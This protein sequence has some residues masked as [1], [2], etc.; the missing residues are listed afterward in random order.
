MSKYGVRGQFVICEKC[1]AKDYNKTNRYW[2][3]GDEHDE[4]FLTYCRECSPGIQ[5]ASTIKKIRTL[6]WTE[7]AAS[8]RDPVFSIKRKGLYLIIFKRFFDFDPARYRF[9]NT[10]EQAKR[11]LINHSEIKKARIFR[12]ERARF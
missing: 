8:R 7:H 6:E 2:R 11:V 5:Y 4:V 1:G 10:L 3:G 12:V 9:S